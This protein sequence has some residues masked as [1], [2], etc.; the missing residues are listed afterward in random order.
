MSNFKSKSKQKLL[1]PGL[2]WNLFKEGRGRDGKG[3]W[4]IN[5]STYFLER[6]SY[7]W[8]DI[9]YFFLR[10]SNILAADGFLTKDS[11]SSWIDCILMKLPLKIPY[12]EGGEANFLT[13]RVGKHVILY[14]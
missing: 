4:P 1:K 14:K 12:Y 2:R 10:S 5:L 7:N 9:R 6:K 3:Y 8:V 13:L 11:L